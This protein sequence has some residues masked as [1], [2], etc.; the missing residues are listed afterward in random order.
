[1][2]SWRLEGESIC[3]PIYTDIHLKNDSIKWKFPKVCAKTHQ[4]NITW[5]TE[6][7]QK[8]KNKIVSHL[9]SCFFL[10]V[11]LK[12][13]QGTMASRIS[14]PPGTSSLFGTRRHGMG[15]ARPV[16]VVRK[17]LKQS[18]GRVVMAPIHQLLCQLPKLSKMSQQNLEKW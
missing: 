11:Q 13:F 9:I 10:V 3:G 12:T 4:I 1:M 17:A 16:L 6:L 7:P 2:Q 14:P 8:K 15:S 5:P 18:G